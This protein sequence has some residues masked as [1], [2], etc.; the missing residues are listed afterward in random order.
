MRISFL[1]ISFALFLV[2]CDGSGA[3]GPA[4]SS[5]SAVESSET[6][7]SVTESSSS[8]L[9][10]SS[11]AVPVSSSSSEVLLSSEQSS[12][13]KEF[14]LSYGTMTDE[15]DGQV[16]KTVTIEGEIFD[17]IMNRTGQMITIPK[18]SWMLENL[19]YPYLQPTAEL[20]SSSWCFDN[21]AVN[22]EKYG[23][24]YLWSAAMDSAA[25][26]SEEGKGCGYF[27]AEEDWQVCS[28]KK[29]V[30]VRGVCPEG[31]RLPTYEEDFQFTELRLH[32][33]DFAYT[34]KKPESIGYYE[35]VTGK[36][37][38][39]ESDRFWLSREMTSGVAYFDGFDEC[40]MFYEFGTTLYDVIYWGDK[41]NAS[42]VRCVKSE[43]E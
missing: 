35:S 28:V 25:L 40:T 12:S 34:D 33:V 7:S 15:R 37:M 21:E 13:S 4:D 6:V 8:V 18:T 22:C 42:T 38:Y 30:S 39:V 23:R 3:S 2:A 19:R 31:W 5:S 9:P 16:Y 26:F 27:A 17:A 32:N 41:R 11:E 10:L 43:S 29:E 20:D 36:F 1:A 24:L 14:Y